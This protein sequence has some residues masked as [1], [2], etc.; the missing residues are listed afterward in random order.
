MTDPRGCVARVSGAWQ[1][2]GPVTLRVPGGLAL[3]GRGQS[4]RGQ[5]RGGGPGE[6]ALPGQLMQPCLQ[7]ILP[8][9]TRRPEI[10]SL[11]G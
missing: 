8:A 9:C 2:G 10:T 4:V 3:P 1:A 5:E 7:C 6:S 11:V